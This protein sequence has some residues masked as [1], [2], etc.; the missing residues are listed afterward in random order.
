M[1]GSC[2]TSDKDIAARYVAEIETSYWKGHFDGPGAILTF[3]EAAALYRAA[4]K[5][6]NFLT[7]VEKYF[8]DTR[9]KDIKPGHI[10]QMAVELYPHWSGASRNRGA[11]IPAQA[12]INHAAESGLCDRIRV[13]RYE[14]DTK[15]KT[16][17]TLEWVKA[18][19]AHAR[20]HLGAYALFMFLTGCR[21]GEATAVTRDVLDL[22]AGKVL[23]R[24]T[25][26]GNEREAHL[27]APLVAALANLEAVKD[28]PLF[29]YRTPDDLMETWDN[30]IKRAK[31]QRLTP[32]CCRHGFATELLRAGVDVITVTWLGGWGTPEHVLK[33]YGHA[34]KKRSLTDVLITEKLTP[35]FAEIVENA[36][37]SAAC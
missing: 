13:K 33:T 10:Q 26:T 18:F 5:G 3:R 2:N 30:V 12:A 19:Q 6:D 15:V 25:K 28:R 16:P 37:K 11:I 7:P 27:P 17:A 36:K 14:V 24:D 23:I 4:G 9:V 32:H 35:A 31:I 21:P 8:K 29:V 34:L 1:S 22:K 20:P